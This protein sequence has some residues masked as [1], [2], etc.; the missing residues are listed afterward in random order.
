M[1]DNIGKR[2]T[3]PKRGFPRLFLSE[4]TYSA[5]AGPVPAAPPA[6]GIVHARV[7]R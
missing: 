4:E 5:Q 6:A 3:P 2:K 7:R 1:G